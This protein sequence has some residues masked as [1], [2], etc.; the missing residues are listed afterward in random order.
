MIGL[1]VTQPSLTLSVGAHPYR[2]DGLCV[3]S[4]RGQQSCP[5]FNRYQRFF[6]CR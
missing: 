1:N 3:R 4:L 6:L 2:L 5:L